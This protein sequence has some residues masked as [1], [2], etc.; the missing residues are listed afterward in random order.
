LEGSMGIRKSTGKNKKTKRRGAAAAMTR[1][2]ARRRMAVDAAK[3][4]PQGMR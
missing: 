1:R 2:E 4:R 3:P